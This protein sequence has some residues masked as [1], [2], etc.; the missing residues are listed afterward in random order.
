MP[1]TGK[2]AALL[3]VVLTV[4]ACGGA[5]SNSQ[6]GSGQDEDAAVRAV[7]ANLQQ[8]ARQGDGNRICTE[9]FTA[10]LAD[11]V[12][13]SSK[14]GSCAKEVKSKLFSPKTT[15][16]VETVD[17]TGP[18]DAKATVKEN[19]GKTSNIFLVKQGGEWRV[20]SVLPA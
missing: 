17:V 9:I 3:L 15:L 12:T 6:T 20:R 8:A 5:S 1:R 2:R 10:K 19:T 4:A 18:T 13:A 14:G 11:S 16:T 7:I